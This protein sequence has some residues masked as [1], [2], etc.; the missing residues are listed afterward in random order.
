M[1]Q[2]TA[3]HEPRWRRI[4]EERPRQILEA[5]F[6]TFS[7]CGLANARLEEIAKR[8]GVSKATIYL[9][10]PN[11]EELFREVV[12]QTV[13]DAID[14]SERTLKGETATEDL[15][16]FMQ[17]YW[18]FIRSATFPPLYR[19]VI[20]ELAAFPDLADFYGK[21]V[22]GRGHRL[23]R[24]I[25]ERGIERGEFRPVDSSVAA[26]MLIALFV[27][28]GNWCH[29]PRMCPSISDRSDKQLLEDI[30]DFYLTA[31]RRTP[32]PRL[33]EQRP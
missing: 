18:R 13:G 4:P 29:Q 27:T 23:L 30:K 32:T 15:L 3:I 10:F 24:S 1:A 12:R 25:V 16:Q 5:A 26:R 17:A 14:E 31:I 21:E 2:A 6:R 20:T 8:A 22:A 7:D 9:Y 28:H 11:K 33:T 19:W